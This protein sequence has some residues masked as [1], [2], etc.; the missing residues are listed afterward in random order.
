MATT[1]KK[2]KGISTEAAAR[3]ALEEHRSLKLEAERLMAEHG[4]TAKLEQADALKSAVTVWAVENEKE[5]INLSNGVYY[6]LRRDKYGGQWITTDDDL[7]TDMPGNVK[8]MS[9]LLRV[10][11]P[12]QE[13]RKDVWLRITKRVVDPEK[14]ARVILEGD[15]KAEE[16]APAFIEK[17]KKPFLMPYGG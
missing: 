15:L 10:L 11:I 16:V 12:N 1:R 3:A 8:S 14:L 9:R 13:K 7:T 17:E 2:A 4:I 5:V 6:R